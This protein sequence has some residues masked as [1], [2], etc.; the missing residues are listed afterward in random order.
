VTKLASYRIDPSKIF[1]SGIS[2]GGFAA[3]QMHVAHSRVFKGAAIY[4]GGVYYCAMDSV[5]LALSDCGGLTNASTGQA[6]YASTLAQS[7]QYLDRQSTAGT[8][9]PASTL[10]GQP[11]YLWS[12][13]KD[14]VVNPLEMADLNSEYQ[15]YGAK[16]KFDN[17]FPAE[18]A[19]ESPG[20][21]LACSAR[22][23][24][25]Y[26]ISCDAG[27][28]SYDSVQTWLSMFLGPLSARTP[29]SSLH[30][31]FIKFDQTEF[32]GGPN[33]S[34]DSA[35][36]VYV[37][38]SCAEGSTC[39]FVLTMH[40]CDQAQSFIGTKF[41]TESGIAEWADGNNIVVLYPYTVIAPGPVPYNPKACFD[42]WGYSGGN[43]I[44]YALKS[45]NQ[46]S[47]IYRMV[48]R[49]TGAP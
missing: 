1:V 32:G 7:E 15:H 18:H 49:V 8:I 14:S 30:G 23:A 47:T 9:D 6:S 19:W 29:G 4:A 12:G 42:W 5:A 16:I 17:A 20:G 34:L 41:M 46:L 3:V 45:G 37:P 28:K 2:S 40:G 33:N 21:E 43:D 11:V 25:P 35:G 36:F 26:M 39:A 24:S 44:N 10:A 38:K 22:A 31:Q 13:T 48:Q 27:G